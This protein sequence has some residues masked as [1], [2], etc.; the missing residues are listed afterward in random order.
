MAEWKTLTVELAYPVESSSKGTVSKLMFREP[1]A[2][3][4]ERID[5]AQ[6]SAAATG[7][8]NIRVARTIVQALLIDHDLEEL[9]PRLHR[10]DFNKI[11]EALSPFAK[12]S[13][14]SAGSKP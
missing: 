10:D 11:A 6:A 2:E 4:L 3:A 9:V 13:T 7:G 12:G 14:N 5:D 8:G 1:D